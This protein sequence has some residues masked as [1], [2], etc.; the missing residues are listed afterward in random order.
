MNDHVRRDVDLVAHV[1]A[2]LT[3]PAVVR[4][5]ARTIGVVNAALDLPILVERVAI[6][7]LVSVVVQHLHA[8]LKTVLKQKNK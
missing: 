1:V 7:Q 5:A 6:L 2:A 3:R 8:L 4:E